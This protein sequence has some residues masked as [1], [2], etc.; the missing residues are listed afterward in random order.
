MIINTFTS[1]CDT[2]SCLLYLLEVLILGGGKREAIV[3]WREEQKGAFST[4]AISEKKPL[5]L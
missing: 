4:L 2:E 5:R 1:I 3:E